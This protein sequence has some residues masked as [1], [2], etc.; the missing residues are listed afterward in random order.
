M[1][2]GLDGGYGKRNIL[3]HIWALNREKWREN[4]DSKRCTYR[5]L[6]ICIDVDTIIVMSNYMSTISKLSH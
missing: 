4:N 3:L 6:C 5:H 1:Y 2:S